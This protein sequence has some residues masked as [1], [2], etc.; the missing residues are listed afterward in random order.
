MPGGAFV[1]EKVKEPS[2]AGDSGLA[3]IVIQVIAD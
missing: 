1:S 3:V 2:R